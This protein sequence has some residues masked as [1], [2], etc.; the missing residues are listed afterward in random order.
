[1][2]NS[3]KQ[4]LVGRRVIRLPQKRLRGRLSGGLLFVKYVI[5]QLSHFK[6]IQLRKCERSGF[7]NHGVCGQ[8]FPFLASL[9]SPLLPSVLRSPQFLGSQKAKNASNGRKAIRERLLRRLKTGLL[10]QAFLSLSLSLLSPPP[11]KPDTRA[12]FG[13]LIDPKPH[14]MRGNSSS[15]YIY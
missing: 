10:C 14:S 2:S 4:A 8:A 13:R 7:Q 5:H 11:G 12:K 15:Q 9:P 3:G 6:I 1:M